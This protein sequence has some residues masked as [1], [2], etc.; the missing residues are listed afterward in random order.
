MKTTGCHPI[1]WRAGRT[2]PGARRR[3][4]ARVARVRR[5]S[6]VRPVRPDHRHIQGHTRRRG[7]RERERCADDHA[8]RL[9]PT[10]LRRIGADGRCGFAEASAPVA[11]TGTLALTGG[12][13]VQLSGTY[14]P[15]ANPQ[16]VLAGGGY[17]LTG[18]YTASNGVFSGSTTFPDG[19]TG[20]WTVSANAATV[21]VFCGTYTSSQ[22]QGGG[23]WNVVLDENNNLTGA[24]TGAGL[25]QG[26]YSPGSNA[27][28]V[29]YTAEPR[30][31]H[32]IRR[33]AAAAGRTT[34]P[35][36]SR[37]D[38]GDWTANTGGC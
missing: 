35:A 29:T 4:R 28:S 25:L 19:K 38:A 10:P 36:V 7:R 3:R 8:A 5:R 26:T 18:N 20:F 15:S 6:R 9:R 14:D 37:P 21:Q 34:H 11:I 22:G 31:G 24:A 33:P 17:G 30:R 12:S 2:R 1:P 13:T 32:W 27:V 16:L 23:T